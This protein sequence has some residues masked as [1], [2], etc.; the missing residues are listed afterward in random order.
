MQRTSTS[1]GSPPPLNRFEQL[2]FAQNV[3][4]TEGKAILSLADRLSGDFCDAVELIYQTTGSVIVTGMGKAGL[5]GQKLVA[6]LASTGSRAHFLHPGEAFHGDLGR[7]GSDDIVLALSNSGATEEI[8]KLL[9]V[10]ADMQVKLIAMTSKPSSPLGQAAD[11]LLDLGPV[12]EA[13]PLGL[14]PSTSTTAMIALG[15]ALALTASRLYDFGPHDFARFHPGGSLGRKLAK[16]EEVMRP[17]GQCRIAPESH[18]IRQVMIEAGR[19][20]RRTGAVMLVDEENRLTGIFTDSDLAR[21]F[22]TARDS[23]LDRP[24][25][26]TM[27]RGPLTATSGIRLSEALEIMTSRKISELPVV[28]ADGHPL[29]LID[30]TDILGESAAKEIEEARR[31]SA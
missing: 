29:G 16:V 11:V 18:S 20:G 28:D 19:P 8:V 7:I 30:V 12:A 15:D 25:A 21:L 3:L 14:A 31:K 17:L 5:V 9:P 22:E 24:I 23:A 2:R 26:E 13:C 1:V 6:T 10:I 27:T 4:A